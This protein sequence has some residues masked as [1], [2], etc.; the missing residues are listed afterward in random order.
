MVK[1]DFYAVDSWESS[2]ALK[3]TKAQSSEVF[4]SKKKCSETI[5]LITFR[6]CCGISDHRW[7]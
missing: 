4:G 7:K 1:T 5:L 3:H 2:G 6:N